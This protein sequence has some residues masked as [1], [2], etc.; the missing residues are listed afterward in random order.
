[1]SEV[2]AWFDAVDSALNQLLADRTAAMDRATVVMLDD[3][4]AASLVRVAP[5]GRA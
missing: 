4:L 1:V 5:R 2:E 3:G